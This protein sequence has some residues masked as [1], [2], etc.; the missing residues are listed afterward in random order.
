MVARLTGS[1]VALAGLLP[2]LALSAD[3]LI[4]LN[5]PLVAGGEVFSSR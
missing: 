5:P 2:A 4:N 1:G 3:P